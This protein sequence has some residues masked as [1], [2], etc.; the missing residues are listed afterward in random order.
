M[1]QHLPRVSDTYLQIHHPR[2][3][4]DFVSGMSS[5]AEL[6]QLTATLDHY[7]H[8]GEEMLEALKLDQAESRN[9]SVGPTLAEAGLGYDE[10]GR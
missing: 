7:H 5:R 6:R 9:L 1:N 4:S 3:H 2:P 10:V 8:A